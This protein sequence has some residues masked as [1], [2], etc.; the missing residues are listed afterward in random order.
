MY[1]HEE[2]GVVMPSCLICESETGFHDDDSVLD[3]GGIICGQ[4]ARKMG[5]TTFDILPCVVC[6][7][8]S[9]EHTYAEDG[10]ICRKCA[11]ATASRAESQND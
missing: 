10:L 8:P 5:I 6:R 1:L 4:C 9:F 7:W 2:T 11:T 3:Q